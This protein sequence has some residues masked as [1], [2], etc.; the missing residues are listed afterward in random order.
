MSGSG[1][2]TNVRYIT[3]DTVTAES[4]HAGSPSNKF[5]TFLGSCQS[6]VGHFMH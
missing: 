6:D 2:G 5:S 4:T 3:A 1:R